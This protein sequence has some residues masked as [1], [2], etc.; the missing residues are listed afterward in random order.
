MMLSIGDIAIAS[1]DPNIIWAGTGEP[2]NRQSSSWGAGVYRS[3]DGGDSWKL[4]GLEQ[5]HHIGRIVVHPRDPNIVFVAALGH[6]WGS[7]SERG[8]YRTTDGGKSWNNVLRINDDTGV[9]DVALENNGRI[10]YAASYQ[11]RRR[12]WG[13]VG[14]GPHSAIYRSLDG[15]D[16][17]KELTEGLPTGDTGRIGISISSS[18][19]NIVYSIIEN[20]EGG[21]FRSED[22]GAHWIKTNSLNPRPMYYSQIRVDPNNSNK[23]WVLGSPLYVSNDGGETFASEATGVGIHVDHHA[24]WINPKNSDHVMLGNDGGLYFSYDGSRNWDFIDNLPIGQFYA[25]AVDQRD[26][27]WVYGGTQDNGSWAIPSRT[28]SRLGIMN[29]DVVNIAYGD[30]FY[31]ATTPQDER[32]VYASSQSGRLYRVDLPTREEK[33]I[34]PVPNDA[35]EEYRFNWSTPLIVSVHDPHTL[36][37]AGNKVFRSTDRAHSWQEIS[38]DLTRNLEWKELPIMGVTRD[39]ETLSRD[40][41]LDNYGNITTMAESPLLAGLLYVGTDDGNVQMTRDSG[42]NWSNL[43]DNFS[44]PGQRWVSRVAPS[45]HAVATAYVTFDGHQDNDFRPYVFSTTDSG[46]S[47]QSIAGNLPNGVVLNSFAE[48]Q[49]NPKLLLAGTESGVYVTLNGG[50]TWDHWAG[51]LPPVPIDDIIIKQ[52]ENDVVLGTHGRSIIIL[53]DITMLENL[54]TE[55]LDSELHLFRPREATQYYAKR[56]LPVPGASEFQG[57]NPDPGALFTYY[58]KNNAESDP[59]AEDS[60]PAVQV[61]I[62]DGQGKRIRELEGAYKQGFHRIAWDLRY[63][64]SYAA[65]PNEESWFGPMRGPFVMPGRYTVRLSA[66]AR[67]TSQS[68]D[69]RVDPETQ[70]SPPVLRERHDLSLRVNQL[71]GSFDKGSKTVQALSEELAALREKQDERELAQSLRETQEELEKEID[72]LKEAL[73]TGWGSEQFKLMDLLGQLQASTSRPTDSQ[74]RSAQQLASKL[75]TNIERVNR[76]ATQDFPRFIKQVQAHGLST[77]SFD[78]IVVPRR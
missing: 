1:S 44:L 24:F 46:E 77:P 28:Y 5:T 53:D 76:V 34:R 14:G 65:D 41:G 16:T 74:Q 57:P 31:A 3:L 48:H 78:K 20:K 42:K 66:G 27:Y 70:T 11:R 68:F 61:V 54:S 32:I 51:N 18:N 37:A 29:Q 26:P 19:P 64:L 23:I 50:E 17:W 39:D 15:G 36:Y 43:T 12:A 63:P 59:E 73:K 4:M 2:N 49:R 35:E 67:S 9:V 72:E 6:L 8:L 52:P 22:R 75:A 40:D 10:L 30:G 25:I 58:L 71:L 47:W 45:H 33:G 69:V 56:S 38:P 55:V 60:E 7:N 13:F 62:E 21:I